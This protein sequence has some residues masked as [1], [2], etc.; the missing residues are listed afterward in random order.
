VVVP[1]DGPPIAGQQN[2][3]LLQQICSYLDLPELGAAAQTCAGWNKTLSASDVWGVAGAKRGYPDPPGPQGVTSFPAPA[4]G[5]GGAFRG[6]FPTQGGTWKEH[7]LSLVDQGATL[8]SDLNGLSVPADALTQVP[9]YPGHPRSEDGRSVLAG[10]PHLA[11]TLDFTR[12]EAQTRRQLDSDTLL[13]ILRLCVNLTSLHLGSHRPLTTL[14][15]DF[16]SRLQ[17]I[18]VTGGR[19]SALESLRFPGCLGLR[20]LHFHDCHR[21]TRLDLQDRATPGTVS[22]TGR[23]DRTLTLN[24]AGANRLQCLEILVSEGNGGLSGDLPRLP[25][26]TCLRLGG[27]PFPWPLDFNRYP[28]LE[29]LHL[30]DHPALDVIQ[31]RRLPRLR[32]L[33]IENCAN[34]RSL[35]LSDL[36]R[37]EWVSV[38]DAPLL[39]TLDLCDVPQSERVAV[40]LERARN[41][42]VLGPCQRLDEF[43]ADFPF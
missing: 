23:L 12:W 17:E 30:K 32:R 36:P 7:V 20:A 14:H 13:R 42:Q 43:L 18:W 35:R 19:H 40:N 9:A 38:G 28:H 21:L 6:A 41:C 39:T 33:T 1:A 3:D 24:L 37:L 26:L 31:L 25:Q 16:P 8:A 5:Q 22:I 34:L 15:L 4:P 29:E 27:F 2:A 11:G 10:K